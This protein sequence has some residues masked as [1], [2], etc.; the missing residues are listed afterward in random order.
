VF[1]LF[2]IGSELLNVLIA[3]KFL[4]IMNIVS[5]EVTEGPILFIGDNLSLLKLQCMGQLDL[6]VTVYDRYTGVR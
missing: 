4:E 3:S 5:E 6:L 1:V 2:L